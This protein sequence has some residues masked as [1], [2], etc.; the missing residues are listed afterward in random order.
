[1]IEITDENINNAMGKVNK[2]KVLDIDSESEDER[3]AQLM[4]LCITEGFN[5]AVRNM[6]EE[7][8]EE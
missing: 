3:I 5:E 2:L 8:G 1:M 4:I 7:R 6:K